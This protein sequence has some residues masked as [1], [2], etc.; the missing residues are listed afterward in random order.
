LILWHLNYPS[1]VSSIRSASQSS[2][3][4]GAH[5]TSCPGLK[6]AD[7]ACPRT[8]DH[9]LRLYCDIISGRA[10]FSQPKSPNFGCTGNSYPMVVSIY[11][12]AFVQGGVARGKRLDVGD[13]SVSPFAHHTLPPLIHS[14]AVD[15]M[16]AWLIS[17]I[18]AASGLA[19]GNRSV[20]TVAP[21]PKYATRHGMVNILWLWFVDR[22]RSIRRILPYLLTF[23]RCEAEN[24]RPKQSPSRAWVRMS[25]RTSRTSSCPPV[26]KIMLWTH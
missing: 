10:E 20:R 8:Q 3:L 6:D 24:I 9:F 21:N 12:N 14:I 26:P 5:I 2:R 18:I 23:E 11:C 13:C 17:R 15:A 7:Q 25:S 16:Q 19:A 4:G 1:K 22:P